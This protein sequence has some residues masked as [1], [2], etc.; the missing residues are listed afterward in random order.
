MT[1]WMIKNKIKNPGIDSKGGE[2]VLNGIAGRKLAG[3]CRVEAVESGGSQAS[4]LRAFE[5]IVWWFKDEC[6]SQFLSLDYSQMSQVSLH[7]IC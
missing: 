6:T 5:N 2:L 1:S 7:F 4:S 3:W